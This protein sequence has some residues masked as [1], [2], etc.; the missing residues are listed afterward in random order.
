MTNKTAIAAPDELV[1]D[2]YIDWLLR[3]LHADMFD[4]ND[5][6]TLIHLHLIEWYSIL[7]KDRSREEDGKSLRER[8]K[9]ETVFI[10]YD[11]IEGPCTFLECV[12]GISERMDFFC[13]PPEDQS[14][15]WLYFWELLSNAKI[16][17][18]GLNI[19][20]IDSA[21]DRVMSRTY[22]VKGVGGLFPLRRPVSNQID[23]EIWYQM[24]Q[25]IHENPN[26]YKRLLQ[27][28]DIHWIHDS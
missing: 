2:V 14:M 1:Q 15:A 7:E 21:V 22:S 17:G 16:L 8:F 28:Y 27:K 25:Y 13:T 20:K 4:D 6:L 5:S 12:Y 11:G 9:N 24:S 19:R 26:L 18:N 23:T 3:N 10:N